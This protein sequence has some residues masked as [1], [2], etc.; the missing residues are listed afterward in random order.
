MSLPVRRDLRKESWRGRH[1]E[2]PPRGAQDK[3]WKTAAIDC[4]QQSKSPQK[5]VCVNEVVDGPGAEGGRGP[6]GCP[7]PSSGGGARKGN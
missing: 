7:V 3:L 1:A 4:V 6:V 2:A 5:G